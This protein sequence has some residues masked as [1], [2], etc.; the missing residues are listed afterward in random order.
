[1]W[2]LLVWIPVG[3]LLALW[4]SA[5]WW[6]HRLLVALPMGDGWPLLD[7]WQL[8]AW[9]AA[10]LPME[11]VS[12]LKAVLVEALGWLEAAATQWPALADWLTPVLWLMWTAGSLSLLLLGLIG[13]VAV[14]AIVGSRSPQP[15]LTVVR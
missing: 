12:L 2:H 15:P 13:S 8:P 14:A 10:W 4:S 9:L 5:C 7:R 1:M 11:S 6:L 3:A